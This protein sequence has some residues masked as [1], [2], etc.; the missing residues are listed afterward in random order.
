M[1]LQPNS[2]SLLE[3]WDQLPS[4]MTAHDL[5]G[6]SDQFFADKHHRKARLAESR[7]ECSLKLLPVWHL[8]EFVNRGIRSE[9]AYERFNG[10]G[11]ATGGLA[12]YHHRLFGCQT[13]HDVHFFFWRL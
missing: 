13:L 7:N 10:V 2:L 5:I 4:Q 8:V 6:P 12:E 11:H 9:A 3:Q 1:L